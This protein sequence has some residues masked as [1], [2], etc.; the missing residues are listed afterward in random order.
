MK[1][2]SALIFIDGTICDDRHRLS[3]YGTEEFYS[4]N[5]IMNDQPV[6]GSVDFVRELSEGYNIIYIGAR[7]DSVFSL[8]QKWLMMNGFPDGKIF[9]AA[10]QSER[11]NIAESVLMNENIVLGI[12]DRWD[13]NQLHLILGCKSVI[14]EEYLGDFDFCKKYISDL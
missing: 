11:I 9:L 3:L 14:V 12:G 6:A 13:D 8:T 7:P 2:K 4:E 5:N 1:N 10:E